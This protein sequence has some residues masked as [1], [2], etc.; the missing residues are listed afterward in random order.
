VRVGALEQIED[1]EEMESI[2]KVLSDT[3]TELNQSTRNRIA[4]FFYDRA[5]FLL[6]LFL[7]LYAF[8]G[9]RVVLMAM[10]Y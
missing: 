8:A 10:G 7:V 2:L 3:A 9:A 6:G 4:K 1:H 5:G